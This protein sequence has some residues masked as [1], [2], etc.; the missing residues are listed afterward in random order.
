MARERYLVN[1]GEETI[2]ENEIVSLTKK[3]KMK[4]WWHY[5]RR[6]VVCIAIVVIF[7]G[8]LIYSALTKVNP[9]YQIAFMTDKFVSEAFIDEMKAEI[10]KYADDVNG[11]GEVVVVI[12]HYMFSAGDGQDVNKDAT[13]LQASIAR[14][15]GD[16]SSGDSM[17]FIHNEA[18]LNYISDMSG[19]L[20]LYNDGTPMPEDATDYENSGISLRDCK[21]F[22][23]FKVEGLEGSY[24][25]ALIAQLSISIR[26]SEGASFA[27]NEKKMEY[28][29]NS[30]TL[31]HSLIE[32]EKAEK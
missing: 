28:Y 5:H 14:F 8:S 2:H 10:E 13:L 22:D 17:I 16:C 3:D 30:Y 23:N 19:G 4:N 12:N 27:K 18:A 25:E 15:A 7:V 9:D 6:I 32:G 11:D 29:N 26:A 20:F 21:A 31:Y 1:A 24:S